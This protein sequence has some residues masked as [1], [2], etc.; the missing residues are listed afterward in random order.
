MT[1]YPNA[2]T[3][4]YD[5]ISFSL[6]KRFSQNF[7]ANG[8]FDYQWRSE[9]RRADSISNNPLDADP[10]SVGWYQNHS[11]DVGTIQDTTNWNFRMLARYQMPYEIGL[12]TNLRVQSGW[13]YARRVDL[14]I[15]AGTGVDG[16]NAGPSLGT[17]RIFVEDIKNNRS[18]TVPLWD[19]R[20]DKR[21]DI[22]KGGSLMVLFDIFNLLN[23]NAITN[24]NLRT[25][26]FGEV[27]AA[28]PPRTMKLGFRWTF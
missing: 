22:G 4:T 10:I 18:D 24:F 16:P 20:L 14:T 26:S 12:A 2:N 8:S 23:S 6:E 19:L 17:K 21:F 25:G 5:T 15:Y 11:Q 28:L 7:F 13:N 27:N 1:E 3:H 9:G